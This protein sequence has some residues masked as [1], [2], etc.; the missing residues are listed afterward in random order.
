[1]SSRS[2]TLTNAGSQKPGGN[3]VMESINSDSRWVLQGYVHLWTG[4][5]KERAFAACRGVQQFSQTLLLG[6]ITVTADKSTWNRCHPII[7][8]V[9]D[10]PL[11][12]MRLII[13]KP[14]LE[15]N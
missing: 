9:E 12:S 5:E 1:M 11:T 15:N 13:A 7:K 10:G 2:Q 6:S 3:T 4:F 14:G 8:I